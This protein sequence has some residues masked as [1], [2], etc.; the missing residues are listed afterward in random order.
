MSYF[1]GI[2]VG[3]KVWSFEYGWGE[4]VS[5]DTDI[6]EIMVA[7]NVCNDAIYDFKGIKVDEVE[8]NQT[9][10]WDEIKFEAPKPPKISLKE[11]K[12]KIKLEGVLGVSLNNGL[13]RDDIATTNIAIN[14][15]KQFTRLLALRDQEC[16][17][18]RGH[19]FIF[20]QNNWN[21]YF[22]YDNKKWCTSCNRIMQHIDIYFKT[23]SDAQKICDILNDNRFDLE[24]Q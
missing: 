14:Q 22:D 16:S 1:N 20:N 2:E 6:K 19:E 15:I 23:W 24:G 9:L 17:D 4:V 5:V 12:I 13:F 8:A 3:D 21:I 7:F 18:S 11:N 10:F